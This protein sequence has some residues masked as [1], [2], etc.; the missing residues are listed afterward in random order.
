MHSN[1]SSNANHNRPRT[2]YVLSPSAFSFLWEECPRCYWEQVVQGQRRPSM[3][4]PAIFN[5]ID[6]QMKRR[7]EGSEWNSFGAE[8]PRF[9]V[10]YGERLIQSTTIDVPG[11]N[12]SIVL[13]GKFDSILLFD[14]GERAVCDF[15]TSGVKPE[16]VEKYW[17]QL[18]AY[19]YILEH[20]A[21]RSLAPGEIH[22]LGLAVFN[23]SEFL[24]DARDGASLTG[25][26]SWIDV[27]RDDSRFMG[28]I[29][30]VAE[31]L[32]S[33]AAPAPAQRCDFCRYRHAA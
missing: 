26:M 20:A 18:H 15:K 30:S 31:L 9:K 16:Y 8:Q 10:E 17:R 32:A 22:R 2:T 29:D 28:F 4:M 11:R 1:I 6:S 5:R 24:Y 19:A 13:R 12:V 7:F 3:P 25:A 33:P 21:P 27:P 14:N 23:P